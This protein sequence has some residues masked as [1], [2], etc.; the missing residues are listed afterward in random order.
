LPGLERSWWRAATFRL[1][2]C[3]DCGLTRFFAGKEATDQLAD[4][5]KWKRIP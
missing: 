4:S 3:R 1:V 5:K 2:I